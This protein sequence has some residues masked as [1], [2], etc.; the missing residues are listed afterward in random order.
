[1]EC[2]SIG[3]DH[4]TTPLR[5]PRVRWQAEKICEGIRGWIPHEQVE[6]HRTF[7]N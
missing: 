6:G 4:S 7:T 3:F 2:W 5:Q 1:M